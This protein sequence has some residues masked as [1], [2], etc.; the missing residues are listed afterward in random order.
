MKCI[1]S[2]VVHMV[3][4]H[5]MGEPFP[6]IDAEWLGFPQQNFLINLAINVSNDDSNV[7]GPWTS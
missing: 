6:L 2:A 4:F 3:F 1:A 7:S 5:T